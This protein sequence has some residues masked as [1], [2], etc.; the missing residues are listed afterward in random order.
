MCMSNVKDSLESPRWTPAIIGEL[1]RA[2]LYV[3]MMEVRTYLIHIKQS[4]G[5]YMD[6]HESDFYCNSV[7][8]FGKASKFF[9]GN[10]FFFFNP[11]LSV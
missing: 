7:S 3:V 9:E 1:A 4:L 5:P 2:S 10:F 11:V 6:L 8:F